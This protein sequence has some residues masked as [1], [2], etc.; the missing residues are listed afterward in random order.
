[1]E[2]L[3]V[4]IC[5]PMEGRNYGQI[6]EDIEKAKEEYLRVCAKDI[7]DVRFVSNLAD[8]KRMEQDYS[9]MLRVED[10]TTSA[11]GEKDGQKILLINYPDERLTGWTLGRILRDV[12]ACD[13]AV[14][15]GKWRSDKS[16]RLAKEVCKEYSIP[17][18]VLTLGWSEE[19][20]KN[21]DGYNHL[22]MQN[23]LAE[24]E[25]LLDDC[26][27]SLDDVVW[28]G[29]KD[30]AK[31][32]LDRIRTVL[33]IDWAPAGVDRIREDILIVGKDWWMDWNYGEQSWEFHKHPWEPDIEYDRAWVWG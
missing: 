5:V 18:I 9:P 21:I 26:G 13:Q 27:Y 14:F 17:Q 4:Y 10:V 20:V 1:M 25:G 12:A 24:A 28:Y 30:R 33:N 29:L 32:P 16:C 3:L 15:Y 31:W 2:K 22:P 23:L 11:D 19:V 8:K 6:E 7:H